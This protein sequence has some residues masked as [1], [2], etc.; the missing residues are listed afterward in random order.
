MSVFTQKRGQVVAIVCAGLVGLALGGAGVAKFLPQGQQT[1]SDPISAQPATFESEPEAEGIVA[2]AAHPLLTRI[3][4][5]IPP[6]I[7]AS[8][9]VEPAEPGQQV[10]E[11]VELALLKDT[12]EDAPHQHETLTIDQAAAL[13]EAL[14][15][16]E[17]AADASHL[18]EAA[19]DH[20]DHDHAPE[21]DLATLAPCVAE[22][23]MVAGRARIYFGANGTSLDSGAR[24]TALLLAKLAKDCPEAEITVVGFADPR[25]DEEANIRV[26]W[27]RARNVINLIGA[28][29]Y[30]VDSFVAKSHQEVHGPECT[31]F[32]IVDRRVEFEIAQAAD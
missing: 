1:Q 19:D 22:L 26:S 6:V 29:G 15:E 18:S 9:A 16:A 12:A 3:P 20:A 30:S 10:S 17:T 4:T 8:V 14:D 28:N 7:A 2:Q 11:I 31:H 21:T 24:E 5:D 25:G 23:S 27:Q 32:D 13:I